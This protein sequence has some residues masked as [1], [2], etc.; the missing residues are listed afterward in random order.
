MN[1]ARCKEL[2]IADKVDCVVGNLNNPLPE[3]WTGKFDFVWSCEVFCHAGDKVEVMQEIKRIL[4]PGG[5]FVMSDIMGS[6]HAEEKA[7]KD[8]TDRNATTA[9]ARPSQ[10]LQHA[11]DAGLT[12]V[13][14]WDNSNNMEKYF[15]DMLSQAIKHK[16]DMMKENVPEQYINNW[17]Q[18][19]TS[20]VQVQKE[21]GVFAHGVFVLRK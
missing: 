16:E 18:S 11:K 12:Y 1:L 8:F 20:R 19:L 5:I 15:A 3:E 10:Y 14:Y 6:D 9:M 2:G 4:K 21:T 13:T 17:I 7:L